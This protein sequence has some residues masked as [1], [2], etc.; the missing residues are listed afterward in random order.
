MFQHLKH[1]QRSPEGTGR[2]D[3]P[4]R[5]FIAPV[6]EY[7][8]VDVAFFPVE[9]QAHGGFQ[10]AETFHRELPASRV[11]GH[12]NQ[13]T[14]LPDPLEQLFPPAMEDGQLLRAENSQGGAIHQYLPDFDGDPEAVPKAEEGV[15]P[16]ETPGEVRA[17][18]G[19]DGWTEQYVVQC[20]ESGHDVGG[21]PA[22]ETD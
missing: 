15:S 11:G 4:E 2:I 8:K 1:L 12:E 14:S 7:V 16:R 5:R 21:A 10:H 3:D 17:G 9:Q 22:G 20:D 18:A 19:P 6:L 13:P